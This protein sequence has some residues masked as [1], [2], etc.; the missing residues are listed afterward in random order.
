MS[1]CSVSELTIYPVKGC[2]A[3]SVDEV[4]LRQGGIVGDRE[5]ML[6]KDGENY[7]QRDHPQVA[8]IAVE[9]STA[10]ARMRSRQVPQVSIV[11]LPGGRTGL[12]MRFA[13]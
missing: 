7:A 6:V 9:R 5:I 3:V 10:R 2:Q 1:E 12:G 4:D 8:T 13:F 11:P